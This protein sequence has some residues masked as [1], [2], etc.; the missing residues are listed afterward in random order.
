M[1]TRLTNDS[2]RY[3]IIEWEADDDDAP[4]SHYSPIYGIGK[5]ETGD[6]WRLHQKRFSGHELLILVFVILV[7][8]IQWMRVALTVAYRSGNQC[9][10]MLCNISK[11]QNFCALIRTKR[12]LLNEH[13]AARLIGKHLYAC[14]KRCSDPYEVAPPPNSAWQAHQTCTLGSLDV[15]TGSSVITLPMQ[16]CALPRRAAKRSACWNANDGTKC[17]NMP[18]RLKIA[19]Q[20]NMPKKL[21]K[22]S[23][24]IIDGNC[25]SLC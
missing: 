1:G 17:S 2:T 11:K 19:Q 8:T 16:L 7:P 14:E 21:N 23:R 6:N 10:S 15:L 12:Q 24:D 3:H 25:V 22:L 9:I 13:S 4:V 20:S 18:K 5:L